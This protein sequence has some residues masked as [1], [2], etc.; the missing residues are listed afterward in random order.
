M[1]QTPAAAAER[2]GS[3]APSGDR[4]QAALALLLLSVWLG[5]VFVLH[6]TA[7]V[8]GYVTLPVRVSV[9]VVLVAVSVWLM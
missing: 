2:P 1:E 8:N 9:G 6:Y 5:G 3:R 7:W 4:G